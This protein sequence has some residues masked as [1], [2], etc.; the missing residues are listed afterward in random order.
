MDIKLKDFW[1]ETL[2][3]ILLKKKI[4][5]STHTAKKRAT[6]VGRGEFFR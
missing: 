3:N 5:I 4:M 6:Y 2:Q 1:R